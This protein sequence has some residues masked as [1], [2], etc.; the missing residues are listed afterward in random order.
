M[1]SPADISQ[2]Y[3][4]RAVQFGKSIRACHYHSERSFR[5]RQKAILS[6]F[7]NLR[8]KKIL[9]V[10]CGPG[11]FTQP[12]SPGNFLV[13]VDLSEAMLRWARSSLKAV[14][15]EAELL[16]FKKGSFDVVLAVE[17]LQHLSDPEI[18]IKELASSLRPGG[19]L[20]LSAINQ[21]SLLHQLLVP[22]VSDYKTLHFHSLQ[23]ILNLL[24]QQGFACEEICFL[25]FPFPLSWRSLRRVPAFSGWAS[26]WILRSIKRG[27]NE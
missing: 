12:F 7:K 3:D 27:T 18:F 4:E 23:R 22:F 25:A 2:H 24:H 9:D 1:K 26:S 11:L 16:P 17:I 20:I 13:G 21:A 5:Q 10:G 14:R 8:G 19:E 6:F 15:S